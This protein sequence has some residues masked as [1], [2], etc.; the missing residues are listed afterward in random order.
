LVSACLGGN[1]WQRDAGGG[2]Y[3]AT[4]KPDGVM[5]NSMI[6]KAL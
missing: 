3:P 6:S 5:I 4:K 1:A 2:G